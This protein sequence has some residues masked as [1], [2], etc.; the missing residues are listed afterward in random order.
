MMPYTSEHGRE[1]DRV[2]DIQ[3]AI[4]HYHKAVAA[5][6]TA[7]T[8]SNHHRCQIQPINLRDA[9][10]WGLQHSLLVFS[11]QQTEIRDNDQMKNELT[12]SFEI[13]ASSASSSLSATRAGM[14]LFWDRG[15]QCLLA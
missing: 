2:S 3:H 9:L 5:L 11:V 15:E 4:H 7:L 1:A 6:T 12:R 13:D 10:R 14:Q 8:Y